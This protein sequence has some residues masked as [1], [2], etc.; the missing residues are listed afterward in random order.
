M[1]AKT[2]HNDPP[3][4][5]RVDQLFDGLRC[6]IGLVGDADQCGVRR[7]RQGPEPDGDRAADSIFGMSVLDYGQRQPRERI[8]ERRVIRHDGHNRLKTGI[9][10]TARRFPDEQL[11]SVG[12]K[13]LLATKASR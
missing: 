4:Q 10:E 2:R 6:Q 5:E 11:P 3:R 8:P 12:L 1:V 13:Q 7:F 9:Q